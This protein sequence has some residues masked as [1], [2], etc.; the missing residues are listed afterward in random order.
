MEGSEIEVIQG[1]KRLIGGNPE[2]QLLVEWNPRFMQRAGYTVDALPQ[3]LLDMNFYLETQGQPLDYEETNRLLQ[4]GALG[5]KWYANL[6]AR[7]VN[8]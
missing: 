1:M 6:Y 7:R 5:A 3:L 4:S 2:I 8:L